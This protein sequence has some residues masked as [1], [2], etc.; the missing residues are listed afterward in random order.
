MITTQNT[1][2]ADRTVWEALRA[3]PAAAL[4]ALLIG[5]TMLLFGTSVTDNQGWSYN[6]P[7]PAHILLGYDFINVQ[8]ITSATDP[9]GYTTDP[10]TGERIPAPAIQDGTGSPDAGAAYY[11]CKRQASLLGLTAGGLVAAGLVLSV[12]AGRKPSTD[13]E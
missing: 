3:K 4:A 9:G 8:P 12:Q 10:T 13:D 1:T 7:T 5:P 6:C 2:E 11:R